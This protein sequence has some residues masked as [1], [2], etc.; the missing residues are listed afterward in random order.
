MKNKKQ[1]KDEIQNRIEAIETMISDFDFEL[2]KKYGSDPEYTSE[3]L[4]PYWDELNN[5]TQ[6]FYTKGKVELL[7]R[8]NEL[9]KERLN[10]EE[11]E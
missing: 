2:S 6:R 11:D 3:N 9:Y 1:I 7:E 5:I 8:L 10:L 4:K